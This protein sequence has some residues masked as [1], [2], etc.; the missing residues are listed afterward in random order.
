MM[1][2]GFQKTQDGSERRS[3]RIFNEHL[4]HTDMK[5]MRWNREI[6]SPSRA[7]SNMMESLLITLFLGKGFLCDER[8]VR[9]AFFVGALH[10]AR[11]F[12]AHCGRFS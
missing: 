6:S 7:G 11:S 3:H 2:M 8:R 1:P 12:D 9:V 10:A 5:E 4:Q